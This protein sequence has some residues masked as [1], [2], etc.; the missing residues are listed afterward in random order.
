MSQATIAGGGSVIDP[1]N[2]PVP[3]ATMLTEAEKVEGVTNVISGVVLPMLGGPLAGAIQAGLNGAEQVANGT[4]TALTA[5]DNALQTL[6]AA[7]TTVLKVAP[8]V[9][10][11]AVS[12]AMAAKVNYWDS[13]L[14]NVL[15][16]I[17]AYFK[18]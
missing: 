2:T 12:D 8:A 14:G 17:E 13:L 1:T 6:A 9:A 7:A 10:K 3:P 16:E 5:H 4:I 15:Q 18:L 11:G